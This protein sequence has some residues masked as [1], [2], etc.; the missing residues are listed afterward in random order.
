MWYRMVFCVFLLY[1]SLVSKCLLR[2]LKSLA[3]IL[4]C[5]S[6]FTEIMFVD[7]VSKVTA[8]FRRESGV[9][10]RA[11]DSYGVQ[12]SSNGFWV[13]KSLATTHFKYQLMICDDSFYRGFHVSGFTGCWKRCNSWCN[14]QAS[15]HFR[16][17]S[18][19]A[20]FGGIA[21]NIN[22]HVRNLPNRLISVA[23]R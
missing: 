4:P 19:S 2:F 23:I 10:L 20:H 18:S 14:D 12:T 7:E 6:Q 3:I 21:F 8:H 9:S 15:P 16:T 11:R 17:A 5:H 13:S 22:G 1:F